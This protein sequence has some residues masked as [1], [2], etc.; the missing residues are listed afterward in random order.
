MRQLFL[1]CNQ[2]LADFNGQAK[3]SIDNPIAQARRLFPTAA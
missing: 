1:D 2:V 3:T